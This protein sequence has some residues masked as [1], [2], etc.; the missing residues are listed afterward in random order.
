MSPGVRRASLAE[1]LPDRASQLHLL[2]F[3]ELRDPQ[4]AAILMAQAD[5]QAAADLLIEAANKAGGDDNITVIV[6]TF[7]AY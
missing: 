1:W 6:A 3:V 7:D 4:I 5:P 2:A